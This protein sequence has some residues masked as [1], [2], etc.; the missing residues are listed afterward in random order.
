M[1][2]YVFSIIFQS[3]TVMAAVIRDG[4]LFQL[5]RVLIIVIPFF[6]VFINIKR[7]FNFFVLCSVGGLFFIGVNYILYKNGVMQLAYKVSIFIL[8]ACFILILS[9]KKMDITTSFYNII[10]LIVIVSV[11]FYFWLYLMR[12]SLPYKEIRGEDTYI[13]RSYCNV[14]YTY[15]FWD[16]YPRM[17][18]FFW[19]PGVCQIYF[20]LALFLYVIKKKDNIVQVFL[21][22]IG[23]L[24]TQSTSGYCIMALILSYY[25][26]NSRLFDRMSK[27][28]I[29]IVGAYATVVLAIILIS[30]KVQ[31]SIGKNWESYAVRKLDFVNGIRVL[32]NHPLFGT[33]YGNIG[34]FLSINKW[35][36][37]SSNG[38]LTWMFMTGLLGMVIVFFPVIKSFIM[39][40]FKKQ[41]L[42]W[43]IVLIMFNVTEP[44]YNL[45]LMA[46]LIGME[47]ARWYKLKRFKEELSTNEG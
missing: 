18:G 39:T 6:Y 3:G 16:K 27:K 25:I 40:K 7:V 41:Y 42:L 17:S 24:L 35:G 28:M 4:Y 10:L 5:T 38:L 21:I 45:P 44:I 30:I 47:Y 23:L 2:L 29:S 31:E 12:I 36:T 33:G 13:Y 46:M 26:S 1:Y 19:E 43:I 15:N 37:G 22:I 9:Q 20:N 8:S 32:S 11:F 34:E 14:F